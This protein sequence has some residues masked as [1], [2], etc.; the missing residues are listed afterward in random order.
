MERV[1]GLVPTVDYACVVD[2]LGPGSPMKLVEVVG[3]RMAERILSL[4]GCKACVG[5]YIVMICTLVLNLVL[6]HV[7]LK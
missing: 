7:S 3:E 1:Y 4:N 2:L 5:V 6:I